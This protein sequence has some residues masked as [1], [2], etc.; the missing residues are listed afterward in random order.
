MIQQSHFWAH[1]Q[2]KPEFKNV[3]APQCSLQHCL[4]KPRHGNNLYVHQR[5]LDKEDMV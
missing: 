5:G 3:H 4:Q 1:T 2:R